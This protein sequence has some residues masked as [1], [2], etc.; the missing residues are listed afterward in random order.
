MENMAALYGVNPE[1]EVIVN[2]KADYPSQM[3]YIL[4][5]SENAAVPGVLD[6]NGIQPRAETSGKYFKVIS[7]YRR[8]SYVQLI[9]TTVDATSKIFVTSKKSSSA[10]V[11]VWINSA[12]TVF[13]ASNADPTVDVG[14][15]VSVSEL[16]SYTTA[17]IA[18]FTSISQITLVTYDIKAETTAQILSGNM[19]RGAECTYPYI[20]PAPKKSC[21]PG[22]F[23]QELTFASGDITPIRLVPGFCAQPDHPTPAVF[24]CF[25]G[26]TKAGTGTCRC[27]DLFTGR[28]CATP[29]CLNGGVVEKFPGNGRP[30]CQC[31]AGYGG[32]HCEILSCSSSSPNVFGSTKRSLA[33]VIQSS[34]SQAELNSHIN[35]GLTALLK[36]MGQADAFDEYIVSTFNAVTVQSNAFKQ[37]SIICT[38]TSDSVLDVNSIL[39]CHNVFSHSVSLGAQLRC[40]RATINIAM[41]NSQSDTQPSLDAL[42]QTI[43]T[44]SYDKSS[45]FL[46]TDAPPYATTSDADMPNIVLAAIERQLQINVI[47]TAPYQMSSFCMQYPNSSIYTQLALQTGGTIINLCQ[48]YANSYPRDIIT[49]VT[50][51]P[52]LVLSLIAWFSAVL[53]RLWHQSPPCGD[54]A[55]SPDC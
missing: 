11:R 16:S 50:P 19:S 9:R 48:P 55:G 12:N 24:V 28:N 20:F 7:R 3:V 39:E 6:Q 30:L 5:T 47:I 54:A 1:Q 38:S 49:E 15:A 37:I 45:I 40:G 36:Y 10:N 52:D 31:P 51:Y 42:L 34:F 27:T 33:V 2:I 43:K 35:S 22:P 46:F 13:L 44:I 25:N 29:V 23:V 41:K 32:D 4:I 21:T 26:G 17:Y 8:M 18:G 14:S 53:H